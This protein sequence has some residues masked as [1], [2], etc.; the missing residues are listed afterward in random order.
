MKYS[1]KKKFKQLKIKKD[2]RL[3]NKEIKKKIEN[4]KGNF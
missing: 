4:K 3:K 1:K 2:S